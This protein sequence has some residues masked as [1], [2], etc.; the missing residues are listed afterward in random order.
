M[1]VKFSKTKT[2]KKNL[3]KPKFEKNVNN[4]EILSDNKVE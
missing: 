4:N 3:K 1:R 2:L